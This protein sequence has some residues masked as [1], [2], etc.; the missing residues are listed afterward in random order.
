M[1]TLSLYCHSILCYL[2]MICHCHTS[3]I[4]NLDCQTIQLKM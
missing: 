3:I 4:I 1:I 2:D